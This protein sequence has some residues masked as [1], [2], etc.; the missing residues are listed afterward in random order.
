MRL[1]L[2]A[3]TG[4]GAEVRFDGHAR[5]GAI[6][7]TAVIR[8]GR[9]RYFLKLNSP[10]L[11]DMYQAEHEGL[12]EIG[13][14]GCLRV[15][16]P[17]A[18]GACA[19]HAYLVLEFLELQGAGDASALGAGLA[20]LHAHVADQHGWQRDNTIGLTPQHNPPCDDWT[21][22]WRDHRLGF[23]LALAERN[24]HGPGL[25]EPGA[26][27]LEGLPALLA[28]HHPAPSLL[29]GDLW[30]G[31]KAFLGDGSPVVFDPATYYGDRETDLAMA[32]LF[33]GFTPDFFRSYRA[34]FP[35]DEGH[36]IRRDLYQLYHLLNHLNLF[37]TAYLGQ[38]L[39]LIRRLLAELG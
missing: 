18:S 22:F 10:D 15:P 35:L 3:E 14:T 1:A 39:A 34:V 27:L 6:N 21:A 11:L 5:T 7:R 32:E 19:T 25:V 17:V 28:G 16:T 12:R 37:G 23:Q 13:A 29:H 4:N 31:N 8:Q 36:P 30:G 33:G 38:C 9:E 2:H 24:G 26:R 20:D